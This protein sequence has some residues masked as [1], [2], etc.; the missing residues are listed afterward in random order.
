MLN[1]VWAVVHDGK[2][3]TLNAVNVPEGTRALVTLLVEDE[4]EFWQTASVPSLNEVWDN[5]EDDVYGELL[6]T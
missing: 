6:Q 3:E 1:T 5:A 4:A 2:I